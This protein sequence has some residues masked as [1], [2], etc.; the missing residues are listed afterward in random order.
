MNALRNRYVKKALLLGFLA[1]AGILAF[2][3][4][5]DVF[6]TLGGKTPEETLALLRAEQLMT[7]TIEVNG[8]TVT[9]EV[10]RLPPTS[11]A[12]P[13]RKVAGGGRLLVVGKVVYLFN[14]SQRAARGQC[15]W[16]EDVPRWPAEPDYV[17]D[18]GTARFVCGVSAQ[19]PGALYAALTADARAKGWEAL[20]GQVWQKGRETLIAHAAESRR[21]T[22]AVLVVQR[23]PR[24]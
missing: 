15:A 1:A 21:G 11:S 14:E 18:A 17:V 2:E 19:A 10:W 4:F 23:N 6:L 24:Q 20:G 3:V 7:Q 12:D 8:R 22:E 16:P 13:L 5:G 9:A